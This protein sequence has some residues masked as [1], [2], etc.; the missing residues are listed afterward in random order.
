MTRAALSE[1]RA[2]DRQALTGRMK[3]ARAANWSRV[4]VDV[5]EF[6]CHCRHCCGDDDG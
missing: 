2:D 3:A 1:V 4:A 6:G 5:Q